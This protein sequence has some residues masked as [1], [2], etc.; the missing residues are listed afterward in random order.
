MHGF[1]KAKRWSSWS[2][3][4]VLTGCQVMTGCH[5][6]AE[7]DLFRYTMDGR[8][9]IFHARNAVD[10]TGGDE[11]RPE[12]L[13]LGLMEEDVAASQVFAR[14]SI[15]VAALRGQVRGLLGPQSHSKGADQDLPLAAE[16]RRILELARSEAD[17]RNQDV[18]SEDILVAV[19]SGD[20]P[21]GRLLRTNGLAP[22]DVRRDSGTNGS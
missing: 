16:T 12:H 7:P 6:E 10:S 18:R 19:L 22:E 17:R 11:I 15:D 13:V 5:M 8:R 2:A 1:L 9:V 14:R 4:T 20:T 3:A 21:M